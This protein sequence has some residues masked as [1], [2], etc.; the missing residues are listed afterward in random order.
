MFRK[1]NERNQITIPPDVLESVGADP[2]D[3]FEISTRSGTIVLQPRQVAAKE[4]PD[5]DWHA[6]HAQL[7]E[8][9]A[10]GEYTEYPSP[11]TAKQHFR[12]LKK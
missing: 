3:F 12:K 5:A 8:Q 7:Q 10:R 1:L 9:T 6:F 4:Y 11:S 2:G